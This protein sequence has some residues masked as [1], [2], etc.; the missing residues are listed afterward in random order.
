MLV[1]WSVVS[2]VDSMVEYSVELMDVMSAEMMVDYLVDYSVASWVL[3][4]VDLTDDWKVDELAANLVVTTDVNSAVSKALKSVGH[5][6]DSKVV[7]TVENSV[8]NSVVLMD[9]H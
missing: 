5:L 2:L 4:K 6:D 9:D 3:M 1:V 7:S 8:L